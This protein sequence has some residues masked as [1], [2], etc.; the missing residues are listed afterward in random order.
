MLYVGQML[1]GYCGG[2]FSPHIPSD[3]RIEAIGLDWI[4]AR[5]IDD[6]IFGIV[7]FAQADNIH[8]ILKEYTK[9]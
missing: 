6:A 8:E 3:K 7:V 9:P 2:Y 5:S 4:V 1:Y